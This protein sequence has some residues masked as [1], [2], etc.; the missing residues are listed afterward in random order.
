MATK[1]APAYVLWNA[2]VIT[3]GEEA[4]PEAPEYETPIAATEGKQTTTSTAYITL[5]TWTVSTNRSG[6]LRTIEMAASKYGDAQFQ[7]TIGGTQIFTDLELPTAL[8]LYLADTRLAEATEVLLEGKSPDGNSV[9]LW[10]V[11]E[12]KEVG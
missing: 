3:V 9:D 5:A 11:I 8:T 10:A 12:G 7:L 2:P 1:D 4:V 6:I